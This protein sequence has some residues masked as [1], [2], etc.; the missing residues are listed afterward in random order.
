[1]FNIKM[2]LKINLKFFWT[3]IHFFRYVFISEYYCVR[4]DS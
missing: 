2:V 3:Y 1:M 4:E